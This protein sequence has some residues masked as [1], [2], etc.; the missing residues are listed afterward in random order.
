MQHNE[1]GGGFVCGFL[2]IEKRKVTKAVGQTPALATL[3]NAP[4]YTAHPKINC[5][6][7]V[8]HIVLRNL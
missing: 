3:K 5:F 8:V 4:I 1:S 7:W 6:I 2:G